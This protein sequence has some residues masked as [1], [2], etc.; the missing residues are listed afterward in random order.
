M[1]F[2]IRDAREDEL[3][4]IGAILLASY[5]QY[6]PEVTGIT[7]EVLVKAFEEYRIELADAK[8]RWDTT[9]QIVAERDGRLLGCVTYFPPASASDNHDLPHDWAGIRL[10]GV[11]PD[12]RGEGVGRAL[13]VECI[14]RARAAGASVIGLHTTMLMDVARA[15]YQRMGFVRAPEYDFFPASDFTVEAYRLD[16]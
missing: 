15:M 2:Q 4:D 5:Q 7:D 9:V 8:S 6:M 14:D 3:D 1:T 16:L 10:L 11:S 12:G 13:T